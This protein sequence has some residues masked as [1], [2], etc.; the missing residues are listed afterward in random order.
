MLAKKYKNKYH[1]SKLIVM[2]EFLYKMKSQ[3]LAKKLIKENHLESVT[4]LCEVVHK[5]KICKLAEEFIEAAFQAA[6]KYEGIFDLMLLW[7]DEKNQ[8]ERDAIIADIQEL[9]DDCQQQGGV[10]TS[11][12]QMNDLDAIGKDVRA[13]KDH[14]LIKVNEQ[15]GISHLSKL[16]GI[17]QPSLSRFFNSNAMPRRTTL[18]KIAAALD[19]ASVEITMPWVV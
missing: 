13:F 3:Q 8:L 16:T 6:L 12:I 18:L 19:L 14:L 4:V 17:P 11:C 1:T 15:G 10:K 9:L 5:M 2:C 7:H